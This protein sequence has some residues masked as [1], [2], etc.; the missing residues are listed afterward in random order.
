[1]KHLLAS[2][3]AIIAKKHLAYE[4]LSKLEAIRGRTSFQ[5]EGLSGGHMEHL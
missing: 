4:N 5:I 2:K 1:M 3:K